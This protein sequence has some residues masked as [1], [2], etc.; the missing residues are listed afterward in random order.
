[1]KLIKKDY[2]LKTK[3]LVLKPIQKK[4]VQ[5]IFDILSAHPH[6]AKFTTF[7]TP[8]NIEE[9]MTFYKQTSKKFP[10]EEITWSIFFK[11]K[12]VG[13]IGLNNII[14]QSNAWLMNTAELGYWLN[15]E[16]QGNGIMTEAGQTIINFSFKKLNLHKITIGHISDN[17]ASGR[18]IEK[19]GFNFV[20]EKKDHLF[21][22][23]K[24]WN[25]KIYEIITKEDSNI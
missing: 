16:L 14:R 4:D 18:V 1:M 23:K 22:F 2:E 7:N 17:I 11:N 21:R 13:L 20:G 12:F 5:I 25:Y 19:L 8:Q 24:W 6:I 15:P 3:R 10:N 9:T